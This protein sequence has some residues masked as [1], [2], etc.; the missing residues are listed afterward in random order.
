MSEVGWVGVVVGAYGYVILL[1]RL[2]VRVH[3]G[4]IWG[5]HHPHEH[6]GQGR[7]WHFGEQEMHEGV[8]ATLLVS[9]LIRVVQI[10]SDPTAWVMVPLTVGAVLITLP[11][12][13]MVWRMGREDLRNLLITGI[14]RLKTAVLVLCAVGIFVD[15]GVR[16]V[17]LF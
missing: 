13:G 16:V 6:G 4:A 5:P 9:G 14:N 12:V 17:Q 11:T 15:Q 3:R 10:M 2:A 1:S 7:L 8:A